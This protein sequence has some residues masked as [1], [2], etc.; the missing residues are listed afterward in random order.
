[1]TTNMVNKVVA[2]LHRVVG[3]YLAVP[4]GYFL[5]RAVGLQC[6]YPPGLSI[7]GQRKDLTGD[8]CLF[9]RTTRLLVCVGIFGVRIWGVQSRNKR[10][11]AS[12]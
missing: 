12:V 2:G 10:W 9:V 1:M 11:V 5:A 3:E 6:H 8:D 7:W 4:D